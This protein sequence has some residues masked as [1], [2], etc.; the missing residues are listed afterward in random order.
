GAARA[1]F[2][3][4][5]LAVGFSMV[6]SYI[7]SST[8]VPVLSVWL[9]RHQHPDAARRN[10]WF[11]MTR[12]QGGYAWLLGGLLRVRWVLLPAYLAVPVLLVGWWLWAHPG[13]GVEIFPKVDAGQFQLRARAPDGTLL[14]DTEALAKDVLEEIARQAGGEQN[15]NISVTLVGTASY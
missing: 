12:L 4:L 8:F 15:V 11:S 6:T 9:L 5:A 1:L 3:P 2:V 13:L 7:L 10:G 14:E